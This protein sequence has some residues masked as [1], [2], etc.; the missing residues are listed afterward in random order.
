[1][2][3]LELDMMKSD[4]ALRV[5]NYRILPNDSNEAISL[6]STIDLLI[7]FD[8]SFSQGALSWFRSNWA[9]VFGSQ[10]N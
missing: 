8:S 5:C 7:G 10:I 4:D 6:L 9:Q 1:M 2:R 3:L